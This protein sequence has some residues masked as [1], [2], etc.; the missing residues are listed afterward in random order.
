M[1]YRCLFIFLFVSPIFSV[2]ALQNDWSG[3]EEIR[4]DSI[5]I[6]KN[7]RTRDKIIIRE[8]EFSSGDMVSVGRMD[9]SMKKIWNIGNFAEVEYE[10]DTLPDRRHL[11]RIVARD[12]LTVVPILGFNGNR[13]DWRLT[14]GIA[15]N[16]FLG[17]NIELDL[18]GTMGTFNRDF[19]LKFTIPRQLMY[20]NMSVSGGVLYGKAE[21]YRFE[22]GEKV[23]GVGY[24]RR[25]ISGSITN[26]WNEDFKY[27]FSPD[28]GWSLFQHESDTSIVQEDI[29][30]ARQS[31][32]NYL[33]LS[34]GESI[35]YID[36]RRHQ[37]NGWSAGLGVGVGIGL[38][39]KS[40]FYYNAG[41]QA[42]WHKLF[43]PI[44]QLSTE[45][46]TGHTSSDSPS[47]LFYR[48]SRD[49]RGIISGEISGQSYY[50]AKVSTHITFLNRNWFAVEQSFF[51]NWGNGKD[52]YWAL[53]R[54]KPKWSVGTGL[55]FMVPMIPWLYLRFYASWSRDINNWFSV[56]F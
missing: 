2:S 32:I 54:T 37:K 48:G 27:R 55:K 46:S 7:W 39:R 8:L 18:V 34:F 9:T 14:M 3:D 44:V 36:R 26:P 11:L 47:L 43:N 51:A 15:D 19:R 30:V 10:I 17:Q 20:K 28:F 49:V 22:N 1:N 24:I 56:E 50:A 53:Y 41:L 25:E 5:V 31:T 21:N 4:I 29:P 40:P 23:S 6:S 42:E 13:D 33:S 38:D 52:C 16:N 12:A 45:F 35:G